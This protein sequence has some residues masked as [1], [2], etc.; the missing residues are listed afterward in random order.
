MEDLPNFK[1]VIEHSEDLEAND[2]TSEVVSIQSRSIKDLELT[3]ITSDLRLESISS[4]YL[5]SL[6]S[7][8]SENNNII[9]SVRDPK[10]KKICQPIEYILVSLVSSICAATVVFV[11]YHSRS[12]EKPQL[13]IDQN[14]DQLM[15]ELS[16]YS[17]PFWHITGDKYCDDE[18]NI[19]QCGYDFKDCCT[20][21]NDRTRCQDCFCHL[22]DQDKI[23]IEE[24]YKKCDHPVREIQMRHFV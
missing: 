2:G 6:K 18:A 3:S 24:M 4:S 8:K 15:P 14:L 9:Q 20:M 19:A 21:Q 10:R 16:N 12:D 23:K 17:C 11:W 1:V 13:F 22:P 7:M 5:S